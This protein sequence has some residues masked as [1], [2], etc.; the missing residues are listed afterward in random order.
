MLPMKRLPLFF[1]FAFLVPIFIFV[2]KTAPALA[3]TATLTSAADATIRSG[4][5]ADENYGDDIL[6][7]VW[8]LPTSKA[9]TLVKFNLS[10]IPT[11]A[12]IDSATFSIYLTS[13]GRYSQTINDFNI[14]R[15]TAGWQE[16]TVTWNSHK[17]KF[18]MASAL[19]K[20]ASCDAT[21]GYLNYNV[22]TFVRNWLGSAYSN[23][24]LGLYGDEGASES[25]EK[26]FYSR[27]YENNKPPKLKI[28]YTLPGQS[29]GTPDETGENGSETDDV[30]VSKPDEDKVATDSATISA[31]KATPST[32]L[33]EK[34]K[35][36]SGWKIA[37]LAVLIILLAGAIA[38]YIIY[39]RRKKQTSKKDEEP[40]KPEEKP[41]TQAE[42]EE[43]EETN[44]Q[45]PPEK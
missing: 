44:S 5:S 12:T 35:G 2:Q 19:N 43:K 3:T 1:I 24:G 4:G 15:I 42:T 25:W 20:T 26:I 10:S 31:Q 41:S 33:A 21:G 38:G 7:Y 23:Y 30:A 28:I 8:K 17:N 22:K 11:N 45:S 34:V 16:N 29:T 32:T 36:I 37:L 18:D 27:E 9:R 39:R 13:C 14:A 40:E 6:L